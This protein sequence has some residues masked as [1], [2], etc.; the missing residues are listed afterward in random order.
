M[1]LRFHS[2]ALDDYEESADYY[3]AISVVVAKRFVS[4]IERSIQNIKSHPL[5]CPV[6]EDDVRRCLLKRF[7]FGIYFSIEHDHIL[8][9]AVMHL[10]R[11]PRYWADRMS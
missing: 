7:P 8:I 2:E 3:Q 11:R 1:N 4:E 6:I 10:S 9:L 5:A